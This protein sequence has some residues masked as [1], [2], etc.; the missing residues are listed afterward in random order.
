MRSSADVIVV[1][2]GIVG[3][4]TAKELA[5][6][7]ADV[8]LFERAE[9]AHG[10]SGRNH[11]LIFY[12]QNA[13]SDPLYR[14]SLQMYREA[15]DGSPIEL[16]LDDEPVGF[17]I[18]VR[19]EEEWVPAQ[20]EAEACAAGGIKVERL[21]NRDLETAVPGLSPGF[22]G[23]YLIEDGYRVDPAALTLLHALEARRLGAEIVTHTE[24]KQV[25][26]D[27]GRTKGVATD[28]GV[29]DARVVVLAA[30]P[31][32]QRLGRTAGVDLPITGARGWLL[33]TRP[34]PPISNHLLLSPGWHLIS[35]DPGP[36]PVT[37]GGYA[38]GRLPLPP[39]TG[40][41]IQQNASGHILLGGSRL[42]SLRTDPEGP[43]VTR[44]IVKRAVSTLP[45][46]A[47]LHLSEIWSGVRPMSPDGLPLIGWMGDPE[48]LFV[49]G[50]HGGQGVILGGG[51][52]R[53]AAQM[54]MDVG[55]YTDPS[56]FLLERPPTNAPAPNVVGQ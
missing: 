50:G 42:A 23:G 18:L 25:V 11:G 43:E 7:G 26:V 21:V 22:L 29:V 52:G 27:G 19:T 39:Q 38:E 20:A 47:G 46:L 4:S 48:G 55:T 17:V 12:S 35:G 36:S 32:V 53:L 56:P 31:W 2:G 15:R 3:C 34:A 6:L 16:S 10:A 30:G 33:L 28:S 9:I 8:I 49:V 1:G 41:L 37:I 54:I 51:S 45:A 13:V 44:E 5:A 24:V 40:M 14:T